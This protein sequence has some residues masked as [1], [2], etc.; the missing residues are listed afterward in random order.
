MLVDILEEASFDPTAVVG[1]LRVKTGSNY[2]RGKSKYF[3][4]EACEYK[5]DF[6]H[7]QPDVLIILNLEHEHVDYYKN[8]EDVQDAFH[9]F[10][11]QVREGGALVTN[12]SDP[13]IT[14]ILTDLQCPVLDYKGEVSLSLRMRQPGLHNR[15]NAAAATK[16]AM[17]LSIESVHITQ[18]L[19]NF[20]G[21]VRRFEYKGVCSGAAVYDDYA[22]HPTELAAS[23]AGARE[24]YPDKKLTVVFQPHTFSRTTELFSDFVD[25]LRRADRVCL[26]PVY[27]ARSE[28]GYTKTS[29]DIVD[30]LTVAGISA[31]HFMT[32]AAC[33]LA[34]SQSVCNDDVVLV[35]GAGDVTKIA[36]HLVSK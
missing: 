18:A 30:A 3:V 9:T 15:L 23:I 24:L 4:V 25:V 13:N 19:E 1:S 29:Q 21:T 14:P 34:V 8:L 36:Q 2:R 26:I 16:A 5:R 17:F 10:A 20:A 33:A 35:M 31:Q 7:I 22:H 11:R 12:V 6:L 32:H 27:A 28:E